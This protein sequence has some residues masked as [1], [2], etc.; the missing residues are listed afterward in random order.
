MLNNNNFQSSIFKII[1]AELSSVATRK[2]K[3]VFFQ[4]CCF[5]L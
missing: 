5:S 1:K 3:S 4:K 2:M